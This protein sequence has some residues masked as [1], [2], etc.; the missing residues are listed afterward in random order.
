MIN[1]HQ[2]DIMELGGRVRPR[3]NIESLTLT[4]D[5]TTFYHTVLCPSLSISELSFSHL[6]NENTNIYL[7]FDCEFLCQNQTK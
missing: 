7:F 2:Y 5:N 3:L 6:K 4:A 1:H